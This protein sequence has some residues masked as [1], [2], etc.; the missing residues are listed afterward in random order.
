MLCPWS[1][2]H[3]SIAAVSE[4]AAGPFHFPPA[5]V[6]APPAELLIVPAVWLALLPFLPAGPL[7]V[8]LPPA[9]AAGL[10]PALRLAP[11]VLQL[12]PEP[13]AALPRRVPLPPA[14]LVWCALLLLP[15]LSLHALRQRHAPA[16]L[17]PPAVASGSLLGLL[18]RSVPLPA[19]RFQWALILASGDSSP[20]PGSAAAGLWRRWTM[21]IARLLLL[22][23]S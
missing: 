18:R 1:V 17:F 20:R 19:P 2:K 23:Q 12:G 15:W 6:P 8:P 5:D 10:R 13:L 22:A 9:D 16:R 7:P 3:C 11:V 14:L 4:H 21:R